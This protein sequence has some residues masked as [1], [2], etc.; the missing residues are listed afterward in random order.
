MRNWTIIPKNTNAIINFP[1][2]NDSCPGKSARLRK[3]MMNVARFAII[4]A[5]APDK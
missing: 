5:T 4:N 3:Y 2:P 1:I